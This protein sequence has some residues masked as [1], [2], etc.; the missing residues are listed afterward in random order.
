MFRNPNS[1]CGSNVAAALDNISN[2]LNK[3]V[4]CLDEQD[5]QLRALEEKICSSSSSSSSETCKS[6]Q[7]SSV[8]R[9]RK[10]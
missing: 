2:V 6:I 4:K 10:Y 5:I 8:I 7:V 9:I 1:S 3:V